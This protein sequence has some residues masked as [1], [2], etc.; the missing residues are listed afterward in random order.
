MNLTR[1]SISNLG[2][3]YRLFSLYP[4]LPHFLLCCCYNYCSHK[5]SA[6]SNKCEYGSLQAAFILRSFIWQSYKITGVLGL[7]KTKTS[8]AGYLVEFDSRH[9]CRWIC[10]RC[11]L[12]QQSWSDDCG[13][14]RDTGF[15]TSASSYQ[16]K[17]SLSQDFC[18][19]VSMFIFHCV[20][21]TF[22]LTNGFRA[23]SHVSRCTGSLPTYSCLCPWTLDSYRQ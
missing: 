2:P 16:W 6:L 9:R 1:L 22:I 15:T 5:R 20:L 21:C 3:L 18:L 19:L 17:L 14:L 8:T 7:Q 10:A 12:F 23:L 4:T 13:I 11:L